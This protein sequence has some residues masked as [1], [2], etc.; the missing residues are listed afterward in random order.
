MRKLR[1]KRIDYSLTFMFAVCLGSC[2]F[3]EA[4]AGERID[5][6]SMEGSFHGFGE[7]ELQLQIVALDFERH[8]F[9][10]AMQTGGPRGCSG[11]VRGVAKAVDATTIVLAT[12]R[13]AERSCRLTMKF[14][15]AFRKVTI[16]GQDCS[17]Y[18]G[19]SCSFDGSVER[20]KNS[21]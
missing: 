4:T 17:Y 15:E 7:G 2:I 12:K 9:G 21:R 10:V 16:T 8:Q 13:E 18:H 19:A 20:N 11:D 14:S 6:L 3:R 1:K 5:D